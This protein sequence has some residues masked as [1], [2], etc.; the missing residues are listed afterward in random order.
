VPF[1]ADLNGM[2][3]INDSLG[4]EM[5]DRARGDRAAPNDRIS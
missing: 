3:A 2:K 1:F 4:H 5:G